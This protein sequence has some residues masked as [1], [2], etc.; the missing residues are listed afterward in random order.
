MKIPK[1]TELA[2]IPTPIQKISFNNKQFYIKRDDLTGSELTGNKV[3]KLEYLLYE[4]KKLKSEYIFTCGGE[5]SNHCRAT[6]AAAVSLGFKVRVFLWGKEKNNVDG[7]L[8]L[9][10]FLGAEIVYLNKKDYFNVE[11]IMTEERKKYLLKGKN[12][13]VIPEGG[14]TVIGLYGYVNFMKELSEQID[15]KKIKGI[16]AACGS[17][18]TAAG[19]LAGAL[20]YASHI[21]IY[22]VNVFYS[23]EEMTKK[24]LT[25]AEGGLLEHKI[26]IPLNT[27]NLEVIDGYSNEGYKNISKD[28]LLIIKKFAKET[29]IILDPAYTGKAFTA[30]NDLVL[31]KNEGMKNI[32]IHTGGIFSVFG[33]KKDYLSSK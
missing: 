20:L 17:G 29:G 5:Q 31:S 27:K 11:K 14:S 15:L 8:F 19:L 33:R 10:K 1:K 13:Y 7:N 23:K 28:K 9:S 26:D 22:A 32:Y 3:R 6:V 30:Y 24:I 12:V 25:L 18:G 16:Y 2:N 21:K 4:A